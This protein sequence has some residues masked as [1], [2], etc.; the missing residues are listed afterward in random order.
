MLFHILKRK[1]KKKLNYFKKIFHYFINNIYNTCFYYFYILP[2]SF[3]Y[4]NNVVFPQGASVAM[5]YIIAAC[6]IIVSVFF[7]LKNR[8]NIIIYKYTPLF[9]MIISIILIVVIQKTVPRSIFN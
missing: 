7:A 3:T 2:V 4:T 8:K 5:V 6:C 9:A 1:M